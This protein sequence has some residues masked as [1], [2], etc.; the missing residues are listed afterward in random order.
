[1][2]F[3]PLSAGLLPILF[4]AGTSLAAGCS[5]DLVEGLAEAAVG[6]K[7]QRRRPLDLADAVGLVTEHHDLGAVLVVHGVIDPLF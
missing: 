1:M 6:M 5:N 7:R 3:K 4:L 2:R